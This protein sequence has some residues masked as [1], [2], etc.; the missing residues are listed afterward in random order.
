MYI[1]YN[2][3]SDHQP[4]RCS[5]LFQSQSSVRVIIL[6]N[7][8][9]AALLELSVKTVSRVQP[10]TL[11]RVWCFW[12]RQSFI[13][14]FV[15]T[16]SSP[17]AAVSISQSFSEVHSFAVQVIRIPVLSLH[18]HCF[19][20]WYNMLLHKRPIHGV[21]MIPIMQRQSE[22]GGPEDSALRI[23]QVKSNRWYLV[24]FRV[25]FVPVWLKLK[26][27][28]SSKYGKMKQTYA[29][30]HEEISLITCLLL[31]IKLAEVFESCCIFSLPC[32]TL[33][34][35]INSNS[36][37]SQTWQKHRHSVSK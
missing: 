3:E 35:T 36:S 9:S 23:T 34:V 33:T 12:S 8:C 30:Q 6:S 18:W 37:I 27:F 19:I 17:L 15:V 16:S 11:T 29:D 31:L 10:S 13:I 1:T 7:T 20:M 22:G 14:Q 32:E 4:A 28:H 24:Y 21:K 26:L 5:L 25:L 2:W